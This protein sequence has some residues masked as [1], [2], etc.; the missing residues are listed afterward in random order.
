MVIELTPNIIAICI[1]II[2]VVLFFALYIVS[3]KKASCNPESFSW[4]AIWGIQTLIIMTATLFAVSIGLASLGS[5][6]MRLHS[7]SW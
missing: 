7:G 3:Y 5:W 4:H 6:L 2:L 1:E